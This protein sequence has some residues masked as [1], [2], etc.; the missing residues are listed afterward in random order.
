MLAWHLRTGCPIT[1]CLRDLWAFFL[2]WASLLEQCSPEGRQ[3][4]ST[5]AALGPSSLAA[6][7][8]PPTGG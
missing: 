6:A 1:L 7:V 4:L 3:E 8:V 2:A 5:P